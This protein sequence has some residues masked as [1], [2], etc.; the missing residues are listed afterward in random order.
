MVNGSGGC[1]ITAYAICRP[2]GVCDLAQRAL[3]TSREEWL[4]LIDRNKDHLTSF[5]P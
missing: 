5:E 1:A 2:E 3:P 4:K